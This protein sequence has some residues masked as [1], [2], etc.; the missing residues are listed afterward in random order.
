MRFLFLFP[1]PLALAFLERPIF[2]L[3]FWV[4]SF[5]IYTPNFVV[6]NITRR[7]LPRYAFPRVHIILAG[8]A[9]VQL[10]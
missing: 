7:S 9:L 2:K 8:E 10:R 1:S 5:G 3:R 6:G 4:L